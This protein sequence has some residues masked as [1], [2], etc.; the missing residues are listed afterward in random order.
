MKSSYGQKSYW[1]LSL[2][3]L[4]FACQLSQ[5]ASTGN[6]TDCVQKSLVH[7]HHS[8]DEAAKN[9]TQFLR[10]TGES[11]KLGLITTSFE[12]YAKNY[13]LTWC[14][15]AAKKIIKDLT[16]VLETKQLDT[17]NSSRNEKMYDQT[18]NIK[19]FPQITVA[20][21][22]PIDLTLKPQ[23]E[24]PATL[25]LRGQNTVIGIKYELL[26]PPAAQPVG[27]DVVLK[28]DQWEFKI[29]A[30]ISIKRC[31]IPDPSIIIAKVSDEVK[32]DARVILTK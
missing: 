10:F 14:S 28:L 31:G 22:E 13:T 2:I 21:L 17:D 24:V 12:G 16:I 19:D 15:D 1:L 20:L 4:T 3:Y 26:P 11:T 23:G 29:S 7:A 30:N 5:G 8:W 6:K 9:Q 18:L 25:T 32:I 27:Q